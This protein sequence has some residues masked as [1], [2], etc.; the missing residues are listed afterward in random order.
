MPGGR[1]R[2]KKQWIEFVIL[3]KQKLAF[4]LFRKK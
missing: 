1:I 4:Y 2:A 3:Y